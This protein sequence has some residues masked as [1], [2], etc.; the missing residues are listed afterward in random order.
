MKGEHSAIYRYGEKKI[1]TQTFLK[2]DDAWAIAGT[3][4]HWVPVIADNVFEKRMEYE[5]EF[6]DSVLVLGFS[7]YFL[8]L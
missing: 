7:G 6:Q 3:S 4:W 5:S 1:T 2:S 8:H